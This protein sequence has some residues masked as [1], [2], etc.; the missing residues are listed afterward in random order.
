MAQYQIQVSDLRI[1][2]VYSYISDGEIGGAIASREKCDLHA[3]WYVM[4]MDKYGYDGDE[5]GDEW[6]WF[7]AVRIANL[8]D[9][10][11]SKRLS[12]VQIELDRVDRSM[13]IVDG[14][15]RVRAL[16]YMRNFGMI[17]DFT[18]DVM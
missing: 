16:R 3:D 17:K 1:D 18:I 8:V 9:E 2:D 13:A 15:H 5:S 14:N 12:M 11:A 6:R 7:H 10:L 4:W